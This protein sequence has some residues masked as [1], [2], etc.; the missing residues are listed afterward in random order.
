MLYEHAHDSGKLIC[1]HVSCRRTPNESVSLDYLK[2]L[3]VLYWKLKGEE[4]PKLQAI[5]EARGY[6]YKVLWLTSLNTSKICNVTSC[7]I[8]G[9]YHHL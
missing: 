7:I 8:Y 6:S 9:T 5:R 4:D 1:C 3:G 2:K